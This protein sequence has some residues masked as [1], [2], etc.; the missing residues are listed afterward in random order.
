MKNDTQTE[1]AVLAA[2]I[3]SYTGSQT[4]KGKG[5][6]AAVIASYRGNEGSPP[7]RY[8]IKE[9]AVA[10]ANLIGYHGDIE[11]IVN[12]VDAEVRTVTTQ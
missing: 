6:L 3:A 5:V 4:D 9:K 11:W 1:K 7:S 2:V 10:F 12:S 8:E